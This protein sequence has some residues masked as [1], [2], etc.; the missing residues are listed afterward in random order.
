MSATK[1]YRHGR[2][3]AAIRDFLLSS[4]PKPVPSL[5][6]VRTS[7]GGHA[8]LY[9]AVSRMLRAGALVIVG[10]TTSGARIVAVP[11]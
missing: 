5:L 6:T 2:Q 4:G 11:S 7:R 10:R 3:A 1:P 8:Y 9:R